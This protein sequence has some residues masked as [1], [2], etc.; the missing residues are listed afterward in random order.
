MPKRY[1]E[2]DGNLAELA[3]LKVA[4]VGYGS[5]GHA[6]SLNL[7]DSGVD[8]VVSARPGSDN[9]KKAEAAGLRVMTAS[10]AAAAA[11]MIMLL[12]PDHVQRSVYEQDIAPHMK[13]GKTLMF[14]HGFNIHFKQ[15]SPP[16]E[17]DVSM[18]APKAPGHRVRELFVEDVGVP[19]LVADS[20]ECI[21]PRPAARAR[22]CAR[23]RLSEGRG[24]RN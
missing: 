21:G 13:A 10:D 19:A 4:I 5:Q 3:G 17:V 8:V 7:R 14:A 18:I 9:W 20:S 24:D 15:I 11:D 1:Y 16:P 2:S 12:V 6:H 23:A 22:L